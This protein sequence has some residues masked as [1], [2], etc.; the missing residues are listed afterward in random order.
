MTE[1]EETLRGEI[2]GGDLNDD[3]RGRCAEKGQMTAICGTREE[4]REFSPTSGIG[5][6]IFN[7]SLSLS[8][9]ARVHLLTAALI[10]PCSP[11][12]CPFL[13]FTHHLSNSSFP[14]PS[15]SSGPPR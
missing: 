8:A 3:R 1:G 15:S 14:P 9:S 13:S 2:A 7:L 12:L 10:L 5:R 11:A 4:K 6:R